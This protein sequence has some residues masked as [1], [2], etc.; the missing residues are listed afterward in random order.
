MHPG[1]THTGSNSVN[2][3]IQGVVNLPQSPGLQTQ[4]LFE[5]HR[6]IATVKKFKLLVWA[7][8]ARI[9]EAPKIKY[10]H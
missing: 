3:S 9:I 5:S 7:T 4:P 6:V 8:K 1:L 10:S 2:I